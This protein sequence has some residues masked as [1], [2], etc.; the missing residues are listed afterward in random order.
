[1]TL[2]LIEIQYKYQSLNI[3]TRKSG[4]SKTEVVFLP[5]HSPITRNIFFKS[6]PLVHSFFII[7]V[8]ITLPS[9]PKL[10]IILL[11]MLPQVV[12]KN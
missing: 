6:N 5:E 8:S 4:L 10:I 9:A 2:C 1:M 7:M 11:T 3:D 12:N